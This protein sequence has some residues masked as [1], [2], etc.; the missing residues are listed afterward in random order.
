M[1]TRKRIHPYVTPDLAHR[2][3]SYCAAKGITESSAVQ[4][5]VENHLD[6]EAK[7]NELIIRRL[8]RLGRASLGHQRDLALLTESFV[9]FAQVCFAFLPQMAEADKPAAERQ[10]AKRYRQLVDFVS[11]QLA[12]GGGL[13]ADV[14][15]NRSAGAPAATGTPTAAAVG[16][17]NWGGQR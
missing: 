5:A 10:S 11:Q 2:L 4:A 16:A 3:T 17:G 7:D 12:G 6:G 15:K 1:R 9:F 8:D 14:A 13:A